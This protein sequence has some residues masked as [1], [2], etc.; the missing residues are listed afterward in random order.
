MIH[1]GMTPGTALRAIREALKQGRYFLSGHA[2]K[3][4]K[5]RSIT[6]HDI[7]HAIRTARSVGPYSSGMHED[8]DSSCWR[9]EGKD[10][11]GQATPSVRD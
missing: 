8:V 9:V 3:R 4:M 2:K 11:D 1:G 7:T 10:M 6:I 5:Q